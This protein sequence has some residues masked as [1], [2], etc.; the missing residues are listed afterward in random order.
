MLSTVLA[1]LNLTD[2]LALAVYREGP[3]AHQKAANCLNTARCLAW[4]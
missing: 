2:A 3:C 1:D 4:L